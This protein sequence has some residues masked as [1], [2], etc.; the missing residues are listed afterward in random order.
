VFILKIKNRNF[1]IYRETI[2]GVKTEIVNLQGDVENVTEK[3]KEIRK[4]T[5]IKVVLIF[6]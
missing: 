4:L 2:E 5:I 1:R 3:N 6:L